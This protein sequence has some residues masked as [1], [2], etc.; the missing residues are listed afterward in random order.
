MYSNNSKNNIKPSRSWNTA[1][2]MRDQQQFLPVPNY[3]PQGSAFIQDSTGPYWGNIPNS[4]Y[5]GP[6][7]ADST[8]SY[9]QSPPLCPNEYRFG[10]GSM[11]YNQQRN[12]NVQFSGVPQSLLQSHSSSIFSLGNNYQACQSD[13]I[14]SQG[15]NQNFKI[16]NSG[17][18]QFS[19]YSE[20]K[21]N[22][23]QSK[24]VSNSNPIF[25]SIPSGNNSEESKNY[26]FEKTDESSS[27]E[28]KTE[29]PLS[30]EHYPANI[31]THPRKLSISP[32]K[33]R[34][35]KIYQIPLHSRT[36]NNACLFSKM[37]CPPST[38]NAYPS[39]PSN[40]IPKP[41]QIPYS[42]LESN[43]KLNVRFQAGKA[44]Q[45]FGKSQHFSKYEI[46]NPHPNAYSPYNVNNYMLEE[47]NLTDTTSS[48]DSINF[49]SPY[50]QKQ[51]LSN[52]FS[53]KKRGILVNEAKNI[54][55][56]VMRIINDFNM[57][58][59]DTNWLND[60][61]FI[62]NGLTH[63]D[64]MSFNGNLREQ[65]F[66]LDENLSL[67][68]LQF[69]KQ[70]V[71]NLLLDISKV[72]NQINER[73]SYMVQSFKSLEGK[74]LKPEEDNESYNKLKNNPE[75]RFD[76]AY[77]I[78]LIIHQYSPKELLEFFSQKVNNK[79]VQFMLDHSSHTELKQLLNYI[80]NELY[81]MSLV[82]FSNIVVQRL[83]CLQ[84]N[85]YNI[86]LIPYIEKELTSLPHEVNLG[87]LRV[88]NISPEDQSFFEL[89]ID[90]RE[91]MIQLIILNLKLFMID[92]NG[93]RV[94]QKFIRE[95]NILKKLLNF[96]KTV[97]KVSD[98][99]K[100]GLENYTTFELYSELFPSLPFPCELSET[101]IKFIKSNFK[102]YKNSL[103][104]S[105]TILSVIESLPKRIPTLKQSLKQRKAYE[106]KLKLNLHRTEK[107]DHQKYPFI[108][109][110]LYLFNQ[111]QSILDKSYLNKSLVVLI[112]KFD[113]SD[114]I[115]YYY[116]VEAYL[117]D[118]SCCKYGNFL[119]QELI[120]RSLIWKERNISIKVVMNNLRNGF[121]MRHNIEQKLTQNQI[122][123]IDELASHGVQD[124][125]SLREYKGE[126]EYQFKAGDKIR[127]KM[128]Q[129][130]KDDFKHFMT[131]K[132]SKFVVCLF[133][134]ETV[135][136]SSEQV[137]LI[138]R[139]ENPNSGSVNSR[140]W[141]I[142]R[143]KT[144]SELA[145]Y[146]TNKLIELDNP[147]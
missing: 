86:S 67:Q 146:L 132:Y 131:Q 138:I 111:P 118:I 128:T 42:Q 31:Q 65:G 98:L 125:S 11:N 139:R 106:S 129:L 121:P 136:Y 36:N 122:K 66:E 94:L 144:Y 85:Y 123:F 99:N 120:R 109:L 7:N 116:M 40:Q 84:Y 100:M 77:R 43:L 68:P 28:K 52:S 79:R 97:L 133:I 49:L 21:I 57:K 75:Y 23:T 92:T 54:Q 137:P 6:Q 143:G 24:P 108:E 35:D 110:R 134:N 69:Q 93:N 1:K 25:R 26:P 30:G 37:G 33:G 103:S 105:K 81:C 48:D 47:L 17:L 51:S 76:P 141:A 135:T 96:C 95:E 90:S 59:E 147:Q 8:V 91:R 130:I 87:A 72:D 45:K 73:N 58:V 115:D 16:N 44:P 46:Y 53:D 32:I 60:P 29:N 56:K 18:T 3:P 9:S 74:V 50:Y 19:Q 14:Q 142:L 104:F 22:Q 78:G 88:K 63:S 4:S 5:P 112:S 62:I 61:D 13:Y 12:Y 34:N 70:S 119:V 113:D 145:N 55:F 114:L 140:D 124:L 126:H 41:K 15:H 10:G 83:L 89:R 107:F 38:F 102:R 71:R 27:G 20:L 2:H 101:C 39:S 80:Q 127:A 117:R 82:K 64:S